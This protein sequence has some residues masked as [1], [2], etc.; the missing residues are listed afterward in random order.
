MR[1]YPV[2]RV[3]RLALA[4]PLC[5]TLLGTTTLIP[6]ASAAPARGGVGGAL[7]GIAMTSVNFYIKFDYK[8]CKPLGPA[9]TVVPASARVLYA[10]EEF[11]NWQGVHTVTD[12]FYFPS[13][14]FDTYLTDHS[15]DNGPASSCDRI[16]LHGRLGTWRMDVIIDGRYITSR[17]FTVTP[18]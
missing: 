12:N 7:R 16:R 11:S 15:N 5:L 8:N 9:V 10:D 17:S 3:R 4:V 13:G 1:T 6:S 2:S 14:A 18:R